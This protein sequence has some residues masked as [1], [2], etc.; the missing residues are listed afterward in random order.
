MPVRAAFAPRT[1]PPFLAPP[2]IPTAMTASHL[3]LA[4]FGH[5]AAV[6]CERA[7][8]ELRA[9][10]PLRVVDA[11]GGQTAVLAVDTASPDSFH[12][13]LEASGG[14][15]TLSI[16]PIRAGVLGLDAPQG[17][18]L[19]LDGRF[20]QLADL[21]YLPA[22]P[23]GDAW[24]PANARDAAGLQLARLGLLLPALVVHDLDAQAGPFDACLA[25]TLDQVEAGQ[26]D[27]GQDWEEVASTRVPLRGLGDARFVVFRGGVAQRDQV[28]IIVGTPDLSR[29]VPVRVHS[30]CLTGDLFGSLKCDCGD[31][32]RNGL[33][34]L[35]E[36][37]GG[38][39][40]YLDQEGRGTGIAA[41]MR[42]Y[43][44]Q[45]LGLDTI[46]ADALLGF[47]PDERRYGTAAAMLRCLGVHQVR[48]LSNNPSKVERLRAV[49]VEV[50][51][52][53]PVTGRITTDNE[54]Y[55]RTKAARAGHALDVDAL[56]SSLS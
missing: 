3:H 35:A 9:G 5:P 43:G 22:Q 1:P 8:A 37:G 34:K 25:I 55:L 24:H 48:L 2:L 39:L 33:A 40:L 32:L 21:S 47:G 29:P 45:H 27:A 56:L 52:R 23:H 46:D 42:A 41:K 4:L 20:D 19:A 10:R 6:A 51:E 49:G 44:Y 26:A 50:V 14:R 18:R 36:L 12:G 15:A 54:Q 38:V 28:A 30:S 13:F 53:L 16:G 31:Q 17:A 7:A 11:Q